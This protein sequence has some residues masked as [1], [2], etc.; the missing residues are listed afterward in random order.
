MDLT[1]R[2][3]EGIT[4]EKT[5][6]KHRG[7]HDPTPGGPQEKPKRLVFAF[8]VSASMYRFNQAD[9][10][11]HTHTTHTRAHTHTT[12]TRTRKRNLSIVEIDGL[13]G[14]WRQW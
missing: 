3:V 14:C 6:Y 13:R 5:I 12:R 2:L 4:G 10:Y 11:E 8:D 9:R 7:E 1:R